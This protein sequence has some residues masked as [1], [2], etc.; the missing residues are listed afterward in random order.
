M[1]PLLSQLAG[2]VSQPG[3]RLAAAHAAVAQFERL[4]EE[5]GGP[6]EQQRW[7]EQ[8]RPRIQVYFTQEEA[9]QQQLEQLEQQQQQ[10]PGHCSN[11]AGQTAVAG[12]SAPAGPAHAAERLVF[13]VPPHLAGL[14]MAPHRLKVFGLGLALEATTLTANSNAVRHLADKLV[15]LETVV[16]RPVWL[17]GL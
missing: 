10:Q 5:F 7:R 14:Q 17:T 12:S 3:R 4:L 13:S 16:H 8:W 1:Q 2:Y 6:L 15:S 9:E 11:A